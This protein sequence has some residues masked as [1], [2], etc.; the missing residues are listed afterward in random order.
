ME[1]LLLLSPLVSVITVCLVLSVVVV[2]P[3]CQCDHSVYFVL[4]VVVVE[5]SCQCDHSVLGVV[6]C[7]C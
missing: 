7:C 4:S 2:E 3:S 6:S 1:K 5:P